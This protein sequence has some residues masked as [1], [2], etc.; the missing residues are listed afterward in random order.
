MLRNQ[1]VRCTKHYSPLNCSVL[2]RRAGSEANFGD[3]HIILPP[4]PFVWGVSHIVPRV[5]P[6]NIVKPPYALKSRETSRNIHHNHRDLA[7]GD[8]ETIPLGGDE[9]RRLRNA[10]ILAKKVLQYAGTLVKVKVPLSRSIIIP[11]Y[12]Y[13][14][15]LPL[16]PLMRLSTISSSPI[17]PTLPL[18]SIK[19]SLARAALA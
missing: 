18:F 13:R 1:V 5:V 2:Q 10:A 6:P 19:V 3:Y 12:D 16:I 8:S 15:V 17:L 14:L 11:T 9:E 7:H 4:E